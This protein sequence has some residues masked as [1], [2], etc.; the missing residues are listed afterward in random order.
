MD[1]I[2]FKLFLIF[3]LIAW[4]FVY[5][6]PWYSFWINVPF[7]WKEYKLWLDLQGWVE[8]DYKVDLDEVRQEEDYNSSK[9]D[10][11]LEWLKSI[12]DKRVEALNISDSVITTASYG[13]EKHIIVQIPLK[14]KSKEENELNI[15]RA[16]E[17]IWK[18]MKIEF[19]EQRNE[20]TQEDIDEREKIAENLLK[21]AQESEYNFSV[22]TTKYKDN[23]ENVETWTMTWTIN[24]L[25]WYF[26]INLENIKTWLYNEVLSWTWI[27][28]Y[29]ISSTWS[30]KPSS[31]KWYWVLDINSFENNIL[32]FDYAFVSAKPSEWKPAKD[33]QGRVLDDRYFVN[34]SVQYS[35]AFQ[36][37]I[38]LTFNSEWAE[39]F[40][41]LTQ[42][43]VWQPIAIFV[44]WNLLTAPNV[45][46]KIPTWKAVI[47]WN[48]TAEEA[49]KLSNDINTWVVPAPIYLTSERTIDSKL[50]ANSLEQL[51]IAWGIWLLLIFVFLIVIYRLAWFFAWIALIAYTL[52][53]LAVVKGLWVT[54]TL[55][56]VAWLI[57]SIWIAIDANILIFERIRDELKNG[58]KLKKAV[59]EWFERSWSAI[60]DSNL[61]WLIISIILFIFGINMI[62]G[63]WLM[64]W[65]WIVVSLFSAMFISRIFIQAITKN[66][67]INLK[68][69][70]GNIKK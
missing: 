8:L 7:T 66:E 28:N 30:L 55:A 18:V 68:L 19:K 3:I 57:L 64:L 35:Q 49:K 25:S 32:D 29:S 48:Y 2:F 15:K 20:I 45:N 41:E 12:I 16:K 61:T 59:K 51:I 17:A 44:W 10:S 5:A 53:V 22:T 26:S 36:P 70:L 14:W 24:D 11:I 56:S 34:S 21:E 54:L 23:Y 40:G 50:W 43:L 67:K 69:F 47:T 42:R 31:E 38:E 1:K 39:I 9:E 46:E 63:F 60:W 6:M 52:I 37:Q 65:I 27:T 58:T 62:K 4:T 33:S 13:W